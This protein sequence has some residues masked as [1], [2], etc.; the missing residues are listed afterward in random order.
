MKALIITGT[1]IVLIAGC[2][3]QNLEYKSWH[4][5]PP[6]GPNSSIIYSNVDWSVIQALHHGMTMEE[7]KEMIPVLPV[8]QAVNAVV[9][10]NHDGTKYEVGLKLSLDKKTIKDISYKEITE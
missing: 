3:S 2:S 9:Y 8:Y 7:A 10:S 6:R 4:I 1:I 5:S